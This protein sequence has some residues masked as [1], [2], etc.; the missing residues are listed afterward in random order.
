M[1]DA[2]RGLCSP[3][4]KYG[5]IAGQWFTNASEDQSVP[6]NNN[7]FEQPLN[8]RIRTFLRM[9]HLRQRIEHDLLGDH[10]FDTQA[11]VLTLLEIHELTSRVDLKRELMK[12]LD[13]QAGNLTR[14][15]NTPDIDNTKLQELLDRQSALTRTLH[16]FPGQLGQHLKSNEF[17]SSIR[18]RANIPGG[19]C[20]F[21]IPAYHAWLRRPIQERRDAVEQWLKPF[22]IVNEAIDLI[23]GLIRQSVPP[24]KVCAEGGFLQ[25]SLD[26]GVPYQMIRVVLPH[27]SPVFPEISAGKHRFSIRFLELDPA[28]GRSTQTRQDIEFLLACCAI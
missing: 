12:E 27:D 23:L 4:G 14:L 5:R 1:A 24:L 13:R 16:G 7:T 17:L 25:Q 22:A 15:A 21:D 28:D 2:F 19:L 9:E 3:L 6:A 11:A 8:E 20:D 18:Q 26:S 10:I